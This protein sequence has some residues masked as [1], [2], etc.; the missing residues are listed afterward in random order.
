MSEVLF[1]QAYYLSF[2]PKL[3]DAAQPY[4]PLGA[5]WA[6]S[7]L[8]AHGYNVAL[9]D[10]MLASSEAEWAQ[11][12]DR[13]R[14]RFAVLFEDSF[15]YLSKMCLQRM[16]QAAF[17]MIGMARQRG[18]RVLVAGS[19]ATD[20]AE[21]YLAAGADAVMRGEAEETLRE[22]MDAWTGRR[23][24]PS[25]AIAGLAYRQDGRTVRTGARPFL[26]DLDALPF[27]A[28]DLVDVESYRRLWRER[29]GYFSMNLATTRGC[30]YHC[31]WC[32]K[33][34]YG[35]RYAVRSPE[36]V[37]DEMAWLKR[38]YGPDHLSFVDDI[39]GLKPGW[40]ERFAEVVAARGARLPFKCLS[41]VDLLA[42]PVVGALR[43]AGC[44]TVWVGAESGSQK[45]L[46]A[47]EKGTRVEQI[48]ESAR[49]LHEAGLEVGFFL[50]FGYPGET[51]EDIERTID[52]V[53]ECRPDDI[54]ISVSYPLPGTPFYERVREQ[55]GDQRNWQD[56]DDLAMMFRGPYSTPFYR[57]LHRVVHKEFRLRRLRDQ[58]ARSLRR[59]A[60][61]L[62][63]AATL[64]VERLRLARLARAPHQGIGPISPS[65]SPEAA[66]RPSGAHD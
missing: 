43:E 31:N 9:F 26:R 48:R 64:P 55:L 11:S 24:A 27:P 53:R 7:H 49:R 20:H 47:M 61:L 13:H 15:N 45:V 12:L 33:P 60:A 62:F 65:L 25:E 40:V 41:R 42:P 2:D 58:R 30:P 22:V 63:H 6:A 56:S 18:C 16:R 39:F 19:D 66:A 17:T 5:L 28:W 4:P 1:G 38:T 36:N 29:H 34:I 52:L 46:D 51:S 32:A 21:E 50:Q 35:Q 37:A 54:G 57:R 14:P 59:T 10:A 23:P 8:R 3:R 44:R